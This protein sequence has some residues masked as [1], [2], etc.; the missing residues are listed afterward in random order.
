M[1]H[2]ME[3]VPTLCCPSWGGRLFILRPYEPETRAAN[4]A[5]LYANLERL[6]TKN[7]KTGHNALIWYSFHAGEG[8][9]WGL[10]L[11]LNPIKPGQPRG[12]GLL[13]FF[14]H[15]PAKF[16][17]LVK[18]SRAV[19]RLVKN[20]TANLARTSPTE[21]SGPPKLIPNIPVRRNFHLTYDRNFRNV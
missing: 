2:N 7:P 17:T 14:I 5:S 6:S 9:G 12:I 1:Y 3:Q 21:I 10:P 11:R 18:R 4:R 20:G 13:P 15:F 8:W 16:P 19:N